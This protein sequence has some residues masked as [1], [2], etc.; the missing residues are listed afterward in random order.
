MG[1]KL[2]D[3]GREKFLRGEISWNS[4]DIRAVYVDTT[5]YTADLVNHEFLSDIP[6]A[7]RRAMSNALT[8]KT[9][10]A[11][12]AGA[13][14]ITWDPIA[15]GDPCQAVVFI[16]YTGTASTSPL[17]SYHDTATDLPMTPNG[18]AMILRVSN[19]ANKLFKL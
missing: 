10:T 12:V 11:G 18:G 15:A 16:K 8:G 13:D 17:I 5:K 19:G 4:D 1:N 9:T 14:D 6:S 3:K 2:F 7:G